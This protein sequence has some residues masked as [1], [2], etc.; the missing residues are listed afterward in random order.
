MTVQWD[1]TLRN[2]LL[3]AWETAI[4][5][6]AKVAIYSGSMPAN[7]AADTTG[8]KL[9]EWDLGSDWAANASAGSKALSGTPIAGT[10]AATGTAGYYRIF[11]SAQST[12]PG[13]TKPC[14]EQGTVTATGG[15]GDLTVDNTSIAS[16]QTVN[17]TGFTKTAPGA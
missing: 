3:D 17:I 12:A 13:S 15:G 10:G 11:T 2:A 6:S 9:V 7:A 16:G 8:T 1:T 5:V 14:M 4:G